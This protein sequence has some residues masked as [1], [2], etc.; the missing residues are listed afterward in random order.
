M[1]NI[2]NAMITKGQDIAGQPIHVTCKVHRILRNHRVRAITMSATYGL[3]KGMDV[4]DTS[5]PL[6][7]PVGGATLG[8]ILNVFG[9]HVDNLGHVDTSTTFH[10]R[11]FVAVLDTRL[12]I[13]ETGI[14]VVD[15]LAPYCHG[16]KIGLFEG[17]GVAKTILIMELIN[18][19]AKAHGDVSVFGGVGADLKTG[20]EM[21][22]S[23][24]CG[25]FAKI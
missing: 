1:S 7:V 20:P 24:L 16:G 6:S 13:F 8:R 9:E 15:L 14:K 2:Y 18:N 25:Y 19:I 22:H 4:I 17:A 21:L 5:A 10:V 23:T 3:T 11:R 12:S